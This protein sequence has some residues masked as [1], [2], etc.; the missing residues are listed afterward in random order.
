MSNPLEAIQSKLDLHQLFKYQQLVK[1]IEEC[2]NTETLRDQLKVILYQC[3]LNEAN[4]KAVIK[5]R[6]DEEFGSK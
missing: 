2:N 1:E 6:I 4:F 3:M 5:T